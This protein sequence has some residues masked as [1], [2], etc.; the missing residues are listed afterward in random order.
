V[1]LI[2]LVKKLLFFYKFRSKK[3]CTAKDQ[4]TLIKVCPLC[5][6]W[7]GNLG[8]G[9]SWAKTECKND[10]EAE[11]EIDFACAPTAFMS[12]TLRECVYGSVKVTRA[13]SS[14]LINNSSA[15]TWQGKRR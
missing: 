4:E 8:D 15:T 9:S 3:Y 11:G 13:L 7:S 2:F 10:C 14:I 12:K 1:A 5:G 6:V